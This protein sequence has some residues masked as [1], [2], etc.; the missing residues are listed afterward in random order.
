LHLT[1]STPAQPTGPGGIDQRQLEVLVPLPVAELEGHDRILGGHCDGDPIVGMGAY[2]FD[3][4]FYGDCSG[5]CL[6]NLIDF[7][8]LAAHWLDSPC[9]ADN[10]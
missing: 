9:D 4:G 10:N 6:V 1:G 2:E 3:L 7:A 8:I 5:D